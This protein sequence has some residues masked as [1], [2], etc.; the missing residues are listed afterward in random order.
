MKKV[1]L[2]ILATGLLITGIVTGYTQIKSSN[3]TSAPIKQDSIPYEVIEDTKQMPPDVK[4]QYLKFKHHPS[5]Y[6]SKD[7]N[8]NVY[9][10]IHAGQ[11]NT[12]GYRLEV[13]K[14]VQEEGKATIYYREITPPKNTFVTMSLTSPKIAVKIKTH[15]P[16][17]I[18]KTIKK[19]T[20]KYL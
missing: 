13:T 20:Y 19:S 2:S 5:I 10:V 16:I 6:T 8:G 17:T 18:K 11:H 12:G 7:K 14:V 4:D 9:V 1:I 15:L 3:S